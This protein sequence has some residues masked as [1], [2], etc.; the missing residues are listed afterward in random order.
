MAKY[1][2]KMDIEEAKEQIIYGISTGTTNTNDMN[3]E[4]VKI[5]GLYCVHEYWLYT[6]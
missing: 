3:L 1:K 5:G 4:T 2:V 6:S